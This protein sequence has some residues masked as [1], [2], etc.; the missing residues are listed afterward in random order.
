MPRS[1]ERGINYII[2]RNLR[3]QIINTPLVALFICLYRHFM[4]SHLLKSNQL[5]LSNPLETLAIIAFLSV[6]IGL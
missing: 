4:L 5:S 1:Y 2:S 6:A 3:F